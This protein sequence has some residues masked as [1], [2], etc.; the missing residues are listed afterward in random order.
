MNNLDTSK[1]EVIESMKLFSKVTD[2][3]TFFEEYNSSDWPRIEVPG[4][5]YCRFEEPLPWNKVYIESFD[6]TLL[7]LNSIRK[8]KRITILGSN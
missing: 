3:S 6:H 8:P 5:S 1:K 4:T 7:T 2:G